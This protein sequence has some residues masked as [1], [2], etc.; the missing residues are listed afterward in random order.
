VAYRAGRNDE[1]FI[2]IGDREGSRFDFV[3]DPAI[4]PDG[5]IVAYGAKRDGRWLLVVAGRESPLAGEPYS[6]FLSADGRSVG[7]VDLD[8]APDG[9]SKMRV[10]ASGESGRPYRLIGKPVFGP[11]GSLAAYAA[12][13]GERRLVVIGTSEFETP[14]RV[15]DPVFSP[16]GRR[17][18]YGARIGREIW[19]KVLDVPSFQR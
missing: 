7:W 5:S 10:V 15:G 8:T 9:G 19:W 16:D 3:T 11:R 12:D 6:V 2:R 1:H 13:E 4:T 18:G 17:V 14:H